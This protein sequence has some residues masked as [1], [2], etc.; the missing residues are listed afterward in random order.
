MIKSWR[1]PEARFRVK[2]TLELPGD[3]GLGLNVFCSAYQ[4]FFDYVYERLVRVA[5]MA[6]QK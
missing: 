5:R 3:G 2:P 1:A 4:G 6:G